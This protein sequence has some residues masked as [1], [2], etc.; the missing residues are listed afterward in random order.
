MLLAATTA[1]TAERW[2]L[3]SQPIELSPKAAKTAALAKLL[4]LVERTVEPAL[5]AKL[6]AETQ[7]LK[8]VIRLL[9]LVQTMAMR[10]L[11]VV[12]AGELA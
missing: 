4:M 1:A 9:M 5:V 8:T 12:Q 2:S 10:S 3:V 6:K 11:M 7:E